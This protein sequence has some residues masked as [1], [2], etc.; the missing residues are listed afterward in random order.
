M[1]VIRYPGVNQ[2]LIL[3]SCAQRIIRRAFHPPTNKGVFG[4]L[5]VLNNFEDGRCGIRL[6]APA[7]EKFAVLAQRQNSRRNQIPHHTPF[8]H[9]VENGRQF[10]MRPFRGSPGT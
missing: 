2:G 5:G 7:F 10:V 9:V 6:I 4:C 8:F 3:P 1:L